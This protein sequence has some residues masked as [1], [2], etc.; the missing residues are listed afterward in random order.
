MGRKKLNLKFNLLVVS[1]V[2]EAGSGNFDPHLDQ[3]LVG[4]ASF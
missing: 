1:A 4:F 2:C 3:F